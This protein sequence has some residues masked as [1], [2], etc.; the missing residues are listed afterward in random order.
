MEE[1]RYQIRRFFGTLRSKASEIKKNNQSLDEEKIYEDL[2]KE[3]TGDFKH[4]LYEQFGFE[5]TSYM[6]SLFKR[7]DNCE[8]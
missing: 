2:I 5:K 3:F 4:V 8:T 1:F 6:L 7:W